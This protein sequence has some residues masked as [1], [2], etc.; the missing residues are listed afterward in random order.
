MNEQPYP[1]EID[2]AVA[3]LLDKIRAS[4]HIALRELSRESGVKLTRLGDILRRGRA[5]TVG[6]LK[7]ICTVLDERPSDVIEQAESTV[8]DQK[9]L[10]AKAVSCGREREEREQLS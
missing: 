7:Q 8:P 3:R 2:A 10:T 6:E 1:S 5:I 4:Q 9:S